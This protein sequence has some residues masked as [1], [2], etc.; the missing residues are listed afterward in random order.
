MAPDA[1]SQLVAG[2]ILLG[3]IFFAA[4]VV[5]VW[6]IR[7]I[8]AAGGQV[9]ADEFRLPDALVAG[10]LA[11]F[12]VGIGVAALFSRAEGE[13]AVKIEQVLPQTSIFLLFVVGIVGFLKYRG[14]RLI[15]LFGLDRLTPLRTVGWALA[16]VF[17]AF[18]LAGAANAVSVFALRGQAEQ[19]PLVHLFRDV[20][21]S[22]DYAAMAQIFLAGVVLAPI[23]EEFIFR[24]FFYAVGKR[25]VGPLASGFATALLFAA[26]HL[27]LTALA[28]LFVLALCLTLA[29]ERTGSL[30]VPIG[31]HAL[32][33]FTS[34][35]VIYLQAR[36]ILPAS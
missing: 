11:A 5:Q 2:V 32:Y 20:A 26:F 15:P 16:L 33:N 18:A 27:S 30:A 17:A 25:Y 7:H 28:G 9:R 35:C 13:N 29:Y 23:C 36:G 21:Q 22:H 6:A 1:L 31:M 3:P 12:F 34:L 4:V 14:L 8:A 19:Q 24:G 10:V